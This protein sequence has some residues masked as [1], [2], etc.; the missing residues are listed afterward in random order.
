MKKLF[1]H[2]LLSTLAW[3]ATPLWAS[4]NPDAGQQKSATCAGCHGEQGNADNP[5][6][7]RLAGQYAD[8][9]VQALKSYQSGDR[10]NPIMN[11][12]AAPLSEQDMED[13]AAWYSSQTHL[14]VPADH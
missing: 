7:P 3:A 9:L 1:T 2:T 4:G 6:Y 5:L 13:L 10:K 14:Y 8:Y 12:M 11:G